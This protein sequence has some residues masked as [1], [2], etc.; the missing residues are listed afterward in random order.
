[1]VAEPEPAEAVDQDLPGAASGGDV[2]SFVSVALIVGDV[3]QSG[4][5]EVLQRPR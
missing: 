1:M 2:H 5:V 4:P 3:D